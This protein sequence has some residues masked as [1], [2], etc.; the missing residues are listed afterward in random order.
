MTHVSYKYTNDRNV[1][2]YSVIQLESVHTIAFQVKKELEEH[3]SN[4][5]I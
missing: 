4:S 2:C 1:L 5:F 3:G